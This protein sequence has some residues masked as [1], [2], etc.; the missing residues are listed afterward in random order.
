VL[1]GVGWLLG[2]AD[3][4]EFPWKIVLPGALIVVG[5]A[6]VWAARSG[7]RQG[8]LVAIGVILTV[9]L[10]IGSTLNFP[11]GG[12]IGER[13]YRPQGFGE[14]RE[15][16]ELSMGSLTLD[17]T[18]LPATGGL[19]QTVHGRVGIGELIVVVPHDLK[20][21]LS[22]HVGAGEIVFL[23]VQRSG[24]DVDNEMPSSGSPVAITLDLS[25]GLGSVKV[26]YG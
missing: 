26:R 17:L 16:Y 13:V 19:G 23:G 24:V 12:G 8:G 3:V 7:E 5:L 10:A 1:F 14:L 21:A 25:V 20:V 9:M 6:L 11:F 4:I 2:T 15:R 18:A 22:G